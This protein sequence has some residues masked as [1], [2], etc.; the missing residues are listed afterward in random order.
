MYKISNQQTNNVIGS[1]VFNKLNLSTG[2]GTSISDGSCQSDY[3]YW[4][5]SSW[6]NGGQNIKLGCNAGEINQGTLAIAI[7]SESGRTSQG[8]RGIAI[9]VNSGQT[10]QQEDSIAIGTGAGKI[11]QENDSIAI[12]TETAEFNQGFCCV[13]IGTTSAQFNQ[14]AYSV[15]IGGIAGQN[16]QGTNCVA[17]GYGAGENTQGINSVAV[18]A[19]SGYNQPAGINS[20]SLGAY[21]TAKDNNTIV[22]NATGSNLQSDG[23]ANGLYI[24]PISSSEELSP[25]LIYNTTSGKIS[26]KSSK[27][28]VIDHPIDNDKYLV[29]AC[30][31]GPEAGVYY[32]GK[33]EIKEND[34]VTITL[35]DYVSKFS[36]DFTVHIT[37]I[38]N[39][40]NKNIILSSSEVENNSFTVHSNNIVDSL[41]FY[42]ILYGKRNEIEIEPLKSSSSIKGNGPYTWLD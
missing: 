8:T 34:N 19:Y 7:G 16:Y 6:K 40:N 42:W 9:G 2:N 17:I 27:T 31:E 22:I 5:G 25:T 37:P 21:S 29:H 26:Y 10:G 1:Y 39:K 13:A 38:Y 14:S 35:P 4:D 11:V 23:T 30:L 41:K 12:G 36:Y 33:A 3:L 28:F 15:A 24:K 20:I 32:R 18:G